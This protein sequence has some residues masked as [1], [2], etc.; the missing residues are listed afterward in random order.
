MIEL[1]SL[2]NNDSPLNEFFKAR[3]KYIFS[4]GNYFILADYNIDLHDICYANWSLYNS[5]DI[6]N[7]SSPAILTTRFDDMIE[8]ENWELRVMKQSYVNELIYNNG[9]RSTVKL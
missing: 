1:K 4:D 9:P 3:Y 5:R 7:D 6:V 2:I 8:N